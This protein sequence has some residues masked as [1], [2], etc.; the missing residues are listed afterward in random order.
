MDATGGGTLHRANWPAFE[1]EVIRLHTLVISD[2]GGL[3]PWSEPALY[4]ED[5]RTLEAL[6]HY[7][8]ALSRARRHYSKH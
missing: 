7:N 1:W 6:L 4:D 5:A 2:L 3:R 8:A